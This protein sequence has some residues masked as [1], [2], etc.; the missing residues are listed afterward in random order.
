MTIRYDILLYAE[1]DV[2]VHVV[3]QISPSAHRGTT[4][5]LKIGG[6]HSQTLQLC[7]MAMS[8]LYRHTTPM[9]CKSHA[10]AGGLEGIAAALCPEISCMH[11]CR[12]HSDPRPT[13]VAAFQR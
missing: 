6:R 8:T 7:P 9:Q 5:L 11:T 1:A 12:V 10:T 3:G 4:A 2:L 13:P